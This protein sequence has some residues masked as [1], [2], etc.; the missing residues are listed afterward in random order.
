MCFKA[1]L[2]KTREFHSDTWKLIFILSCPFLLVS[3]AVSNS[4][5]VYAILQHCVEPLGKVTHK[6]FLDENL[7]SAPSGVDPAPV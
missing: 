1:E 7:E 2:K 5:L 4:L 3:T 6:I